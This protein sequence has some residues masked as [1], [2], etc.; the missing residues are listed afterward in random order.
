M[1]YNLGVIKSWTISKCVKM[2]EVLFWKVII[3]AICQPLHFLQYNRQVYHILIV[4]VCHWISLIGTIEK[5]VSTSNV[6]KI[7]FFSLQFNGETEIKP[8]QSHSSVDN[9]RS[10]TCNL[11]MCGYVSS[12][13]WWVSSHYFIDTEV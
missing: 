10:S 6:Q 9:F 7:Q 4:I 12:I 5:L 3:V 13:I 2:L 11:S 8:I 1:I